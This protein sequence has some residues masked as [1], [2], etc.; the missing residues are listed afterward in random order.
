MPLRAANAP[1]GPSYR[2]SEAAEHHQGVD[3]PKARMAEGRREAAP[4]FPGPTKVHGRH[5]GTDHEARANDGLEHPPS[6]PA[7]RLFG[8][9]DQQLWVHAVYLRRQELF[10]YHWRHKV[11]G[12]VPLELRSLQWPRV[13]IGKASFASPSCRSPSR[14]ITPSSR[15]PRFPSGR[16]T[17][18][19]AAASTTPRR[20][21]ASAR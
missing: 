20:C 9:P 8:R 15:S 10:C 3:G 6:D 14:S 1:D 13:R 4:R 11:G 19:P 7:V 12:C 21:R 17:N 2:A 16:S 5:V 18:P